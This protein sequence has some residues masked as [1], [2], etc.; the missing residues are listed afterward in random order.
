MEINDENGKFHLNRS[1]KVLKQC[2][3]FLNVDPLRLTVSDKKTE[4]MLRLSWCKEVENYETF[5]ILS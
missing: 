5:L 4:Y 3:S 1:V 2:L